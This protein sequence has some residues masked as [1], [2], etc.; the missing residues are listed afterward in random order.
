MRIAIIENGVVINICEADQEW[1]D[2][3]KGIPTD[4]AGIGW[5]Y[6]KKK[7]IQPTQD[8]SLL[9]PLQ[10]EVFN[11]TYL[12]EVSTPITYMNR[13]FQADSKSQEILNRVIASFSTGLPEGFYWV[14]STNNKIPMDIVQL[15]GLSSTIAK[16]NWEAFN[17]L[18]LK[19]EAVIL[20]KTPEELQNIK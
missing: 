8:I 4:I 3:N 1:A 10:I 13:V 12:T 18:Q 7:F 15:Q 17:N 2:A 14:D 20:A 11:K 9:K 6:S 5:K 19:K 16:R